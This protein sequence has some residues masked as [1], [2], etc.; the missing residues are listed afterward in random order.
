MV[1]NGIIYSLL[2]SPACGGK[3]SSCL[4]A[5]RADTG[6]L[7]W[8]SQNLLPASFAQDPLRM[9]LFSFTGKLI[10]NGKALYI[11]SSAGLLALDAGN[12]HVLWQH[13]EDFYVSWS[14]TELKT[15][16]ASVPRLV[17]FGQLEGLMTGTTSY[18]F[19]SVGELDAL[20]NQTGKHLWSLKL[21]EKAPAL[22]TI[23]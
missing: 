15:V 18:V 22:L 16:A 14:G 9:P 10:A 7:L 8:H 23:L 12:G 3:N 4:F 13:V 6:T 21:L 11:D 2:S 20:D 1:A 19:P 5:W 17:G